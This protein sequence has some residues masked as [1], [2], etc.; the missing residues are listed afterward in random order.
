MN[1][2]K[3]EVRTEVKLPEKATIFLIAIALLAARRL[4][5]YLA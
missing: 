1:M 2:V 3:S 5:D 4:R